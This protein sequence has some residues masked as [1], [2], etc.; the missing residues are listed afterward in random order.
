[1][2]SKV[3]NEIYTCVGVLF[4]ILAIGL[5]VVYSI[6]GLWPF[7][8]GGFFVALFVAWVVYSSHQAK[9][10]PRPQVT[11]EPAIMTSFQHVSPEERQKMLEKRGFTHTRMKMAIF[12]GKHLRFLG[13]GPKLRT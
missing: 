5:Y 11:N 1:M 2:S 4:L 10:H 6:Y 9:K 7:V 12:D 13:N 8:I 3:K